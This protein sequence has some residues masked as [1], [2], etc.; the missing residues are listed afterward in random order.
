MKRTLSFTVCCLLT[1][2][3]VTSCSQ[4][5][6]MVQQVTANASYFEDPA[7][8]DFIASVEAIN[9]RYQSSLTRINMQNVSD[10]CEWLLVGV[11]ADGLGGVGGVFGSAV[12]STAYSKYL[13]YCKSQMR[14]RRDN[15]ETSKLYVN[16][17]SDSI[18][19]ELEP[20][21]AF[22]FCDDKP[23]T[24]S[25]SIGI[26]HNQLLNDIELST[27]G[28]IS[29]YG[30]F[31]IIKLVQDIK[32]IVSEK[33]LA[34]TLELNTIDDN[35]LLFCHET[36]S[37]L[38]SIR[39]DRTNMDYVFDEIANSLRD[40]IKVNSDDAYFLTTLA[41]Q[42][43][44]PM[45]VDIDR[46]N[47]VSYSKSLNEALRNSQLSEKDVIYAKNLFQIVVCSSLYWNTQIKVVY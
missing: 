33:G 8:S 22:I 32:S 29:S 17:Y 1:M 41:R 39:Y 37:A 15:Q 11:V 6:E 5:E 30:K 18:Y 31:D 14:S 24:A 28:D 43:I 44:E 23:R 13:D 34:D 4:S 47:I 45:A 2:F 25:D 35:F 16:I 19:K 12:A 20:Q 3:I 46:S 38:S 42:L 27:D 21:I 10:A 26:R 7:R 9:K 40:N 36:I